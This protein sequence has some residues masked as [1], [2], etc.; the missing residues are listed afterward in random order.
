MTN[1]TRRR[2]KDYTISSALE[3]RLS[4]ET[5]GRVSVSSQWLCSSILCWWTIGSIFDYDDLPLLESYL[6]ME[7]V[8]LME[9]YIAIVLFSFLKKKEIA[10]IHQR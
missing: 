3:E 4:N 10:E 8:S 1:D 9:V 5:R 7:L 2:K 6:Y